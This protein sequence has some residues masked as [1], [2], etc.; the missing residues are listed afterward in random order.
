MLKDAIPFAEVGK[1]LDDCVATD[2]RT[3]ADNH[4]IFNHCVRPKPNASSKSYSFTDE[5]SGMNVGGRRKFH[6]YE[7][8]KG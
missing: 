3:W 6:N 1:A 4:I 7:T 2:V 8:E 5:R